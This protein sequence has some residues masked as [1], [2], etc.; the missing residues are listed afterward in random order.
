VGFTFRKA[1]AIV[2]NDRQL[3]AADHAH[4]H[5]WRADE[6]AD[7]PSWE[8]LAT[9]A[10]ARDILPTKTIYESI[11]RE[12]LHMRRYAESVR[13]IDFDL[14]ERRQQHKRH[15][16]LAQKADDLAENYKWA[17]GYSGI[18]NFFGRFLS[19]V[20][21]LRALHRKEAELLRQ[22]AG[23]PPVSAARVSRQ[24]VRGGL[25][26]FGAGSG[27]GSRYIPGRRRAC[28][29]DGGGRRPPRKPPS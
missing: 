5:R 15:L 24:D 19:P 7:D 6:F 17:E 3:T 21:E 11:I 27:A 26:R 22:R 8:Q 12:A 10:R 20:A 16:E 23:R 25:R 28:S 29:R 1:L 14:R 9:A 13:S 4:L 18:A 2:V